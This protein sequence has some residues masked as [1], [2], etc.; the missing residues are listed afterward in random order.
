MKLHLELGSMQSREVEAAVLHGSRLFHSLGLN[1][2]E[3]ES[4][5]STLGL[6]RLDEGANRVHTAG[7]IWNEASTLKRHLRGDRLNVHTRDFSISLLS[8]G[9]A[10]RPETEQEAL[11]L[12]A[13]LA[14]GRALT[15]GFLRPEQLLGLLAAGGIGLNA[16]GVQEHQALISSLGEQSPTAAR[17]MGERGIAEMNGLV[18]VYAPSLWV[19]R[20]A[21]TVGLGDAL[22]SA[23]FAGNL[24]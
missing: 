12:G 18:L 9:Y 7:S 19:E 10:G 3:L 4:A 14:G 16:N 5:L 1:E 23:S 6:R 8:G 2:D 13:A 17:E 11:L 21:S 20:T 24:R 15:G 22:S